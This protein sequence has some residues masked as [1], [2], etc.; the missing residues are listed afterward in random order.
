MNDRTNGRTFSYY[1]APAAAMDMIDGLSPKAFYDEIPSKGGKTP[2]INYKGIS[3]L[4]GLTKCHITSIEETEE[5]D[6]KW[7]VLKATAENPEGHKGF[8]WISRPKHDR[9]EEDDEDYREKAYTHVKRNALRDLVPWQVFLEMLLKKSAQP[10]VQ[11]PMP[12]PQPSE[13]EVAK[14]KARQAIRENREMLTDVYDVTT[15]DIIEKC[16]DRWDLSHIQWLENH[17]EQFTTIIKDP[18][19]IGIASPEDKDEDA[20]PI[21]IE[22]SDDDNDEEQ[23]NLI[24]DFINEIEGK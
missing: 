14:E 2:M 16:E 1:E 17:W 10:Q 23:S 3:L 21:P 18:T 7:L 19:L 20:V 24:D 15:D 6:G 11:N 12:D 9:R 5:S 13:L 22:S 4:A 8:A